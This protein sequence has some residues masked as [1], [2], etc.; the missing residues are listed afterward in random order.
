MDT[1]CTKRYIKFQSNL[2]RTIP[3][4]EYMSVLEAVEANWFRFAAHA[5]NIY[6]FKSIIETIEKGVKNIQ[7]EQ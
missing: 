7:I 1:V 5:E 4:V 6:L 3:L 2:D